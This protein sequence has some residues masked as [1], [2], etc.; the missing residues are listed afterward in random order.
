MK[1]IKYPWASQFIENCRH[2]DGFATET[3]RLS[4]LNDTP[5]DKRLS[6]AFSWRST[7]QGWDY[8]NRLRHRR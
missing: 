7:P 3:A 8:W 1:N 4:I 6:I 5:L 2:E